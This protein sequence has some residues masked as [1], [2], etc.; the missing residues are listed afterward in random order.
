MGRFRIVSVAIMCGLGI[1]GA[2][3]R[4][5]AAPGHHAAHAAARPAHPAAAAKEATPASGWNA[6]QCGR[7][8]VAP[9][10]DTTTVDR[11]NAS[12]DRVTTYERAAR[13]YNACVSKAATTEQTAISNDARLRIDAIQQVSGGVQKRIA[14]NFTALTGALR[15]GGPKLQP[16]H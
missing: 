1:A 12:V 4:A 2:T 16:T 9:T 13:S 11:Y 6:A 15:A 8:P 7:E 5:G 3:V 10:V 14:A